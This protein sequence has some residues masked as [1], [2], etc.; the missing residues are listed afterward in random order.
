MR[1]GA[2]IQARDK[3][4][5]SLA[6]DQ[7]VKVVSGQNKGTIGPI[8]HYDRNY[9]FLWNRE[10]VQSNGIFVESCR[11]VEILGRD[12]VKGDPDKAI[13]SQNK[14]VRDPLVGKV[15]IINGGIYKG[16]RGRVC[17][18]ND[19]TVTVELS[20]VCKKIPIDKALVQA[21]NPEESQKG[22][23]DGHGGGRSVYD[24]NRSMYGGATAYDG[25]KTPMINPTTDNYYPQSQ[26]GG[27]ALNDYG[28][29][30]QDNQ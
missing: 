26:W 3:V 23:G 19:K 22:Q 14:I 18:G 21:V 5:N 6:I 12:F 7:M 24:G 27:G 10:F 29:D 1:S 4:G 8:R 13:A 25:G 11:N 20:T 30:G 17:Y 16:H 2:V 9:L 15:V 28:N